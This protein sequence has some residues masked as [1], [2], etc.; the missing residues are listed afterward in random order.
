M[1]DKLEVRVPAGTPFSR[2]FERV[3]SEIAHSEDFYKHFRPSQHY[4]QVGDLRPLGHSSIL[5]FSNK[6]GKEGNSKLELLDCGKM[7]YS[8]MLDEIEGVFK[9]NPGALDVM[10]VDAAADVPNVPVAWFH[11]AARAKYKQFAQQVSKEKLEIQ[12][13]TMGKREI[14]TLYFGKRPNCI[15]VYNKIAEF[16]HEY[17]GFLR[18]I[19]NS[20]DNGP[21]LRAIPTFEEIYQRQRTDVLTR[22]ERQM[23]GGR[24]P[25]KLTIVATL[26]RHGAEYN[27][28]DKIEFTNSAQMRPEPNP[29]NYK[30]KTYAAGMYFRQRIEAEGMHFFRAWVNRHSRRNAD[31][32]IKEFRDFLPEEITSAPGITEV[33]LFERYRDSFARQMAA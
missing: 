15:R 30:L 4:L 29:W 19:Q 27:P 8:Q 1:I 22:V 13:D 17:S 6:H 5:H 26:K 18:K 32:I 21:C 12:S 9:V 3:Y 28:F 7:G 16:E 25:H 31:K 33:E 24:I 11:G 14:Q 2:K 23:A 10:R 20:A